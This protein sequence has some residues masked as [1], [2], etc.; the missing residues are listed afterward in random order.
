MAPSRIGLLL[1]AA[2]TTSLV[3]CADTPDHSPAAARPAAQAAPPSGSTQPTLVV[4]GGRVFDPASMSLHPPADLWIAG[5]RVLGEQPAGTPAPTGVATLDAS[6][7]TVLPGLFDLHVHLAVTGAS[8]NDFIPVPMEDELRAHLQC[9]VTSV[10]DLHNEPSTVFALRDRSRVEPDL[11]RL[12]AAGGAFTAPG[13]HGTQFGFETNA[14]TSAEEVEERFATLLPQ[15]PDLVKAIVEHGGWSGLPEM[16]ALDEELLG[17][18]EAHARQAG[19]PLLT[20]VWTLDEALT[21]ARRG[22][23]A[24][25][26]G[27]YIGD[28]TP[29]LVELMKRN[30]V[31]YIPTLAVTEGALRVAQGRTPYRNE[32][33][34]QAL[35]PDVYASVSGDT[36]STFVQETGIG[37]GVAQWFA[38]LKALADAGVLIGTGTDAG[39]PLTPHGPS[40]LEELALYVEAGLSPARALRAATLDSATILGVQRDF[41]ALE[42]GQVADL[43]VVP[44][45]PTAE[46]A[47]LWDVRAVVKGGAVV[48]RQAFAAANAA[49]F[50]PAETKVAGRDLPARLDD[51]TTLGASAWGG[52]WTVITDQ[53]TGMG[54][55]TGE[56][57]LADGALRLSGTLAQ[58]FPWGPWSGVVVSFD[59]ARKLL[60]DAS[61]FTG[62]RLRVRGTERLYTF[63][64]Q[65]AAV[66]DYNVF[67]TVLPV[68][69]EWAEVEVPFASL[70]Q[71]GFGAPV[72]WAANDFTGLAIDARN[73]PMTGGT[74]G[75]FWMEID[76][77]E[78]Y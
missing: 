12:Y 8:M 64:P 23:T 72:D 55:S 17:A 43:L 65:R 59:P 2:A 10:A 50:K 48:D 74:W 39:N 67:S 21:A 54:Q 42:P 76:W 28:V 78:L 16:P 57:S 18:V 9:G 40:L 20:H 46:I 70:R 5:E 62:F 1:A 58:G 26:H 7:C 52:D 41:G 32:L 35:H 53:V 4:R 22:V 47:A 3:A 19:L 56:L 13:G 75:D 49:R 73:P 61:A 44:G 24:F 68:G 27:V 66:K 69:P 6:G 14:V 25:A 31:G 77:I 33:S 37:G 60:V 51:F 45:D 38:N 29:E 63:S 34:R 36:G 11:A 15:E 30:D 71:I